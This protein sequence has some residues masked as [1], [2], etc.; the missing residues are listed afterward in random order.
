VKSIFQ[1]LYNM[2]IAKEQS[3]TDLKSCGSKWPNSLNVGRIGPINFTTNDIEHLSQSI[4][5]INQSTLS[6]L[7]KYHFIYKLFTNL[8]KETDL[9]CSVEPSILVFSSRKSNINSKRKSVSNN[10]INPL[11]RLV[12]SQGILNK[13]ISDLKTNNDLSNQPFCGILGITSGDSIGLVPGSHQKFD[14]LL[15]YMQT[16][17]H[18]DKRTIYSSKPPKEFDMEKYLI[19]I[20][21][22]SGELLVFNKKIPFKLNP[23]SIDF[24]QER[25]NK[26]EIDSNL[27]EPFLALCVSFFPKSELLDYEK[28]MRYISYMK[29]IPGN[30][31]KIYGYI[32]NPK[33][34]GLPGLIPFPFMEKEN[35]YK[36][37]ENTD[38]KNVR[39]I[40][41]HE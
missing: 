29:K 7:I 38:D 4:D 32:E 21:L 6:Y 19:Q 30:D 8:M 28:A 26:F 20:P 31:L 37:I 24:L 15:S 1:E 27:S 17:R 11:T 41:G 36:N 22:E 35:W 3:I 23:I 13:S 34:R 2:N 25:K 16:A 18:T 33:R 12:Y 39:S 14:D 40:I 5:I 10:S 9:L